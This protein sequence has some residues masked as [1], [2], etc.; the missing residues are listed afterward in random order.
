MLGEDFPA[1]LPWSHSLW[2]F[3][4]YVPHSVRYL[5]NYPQVVLSE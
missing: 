5:N 3:E 2:R 4:L 1:Q